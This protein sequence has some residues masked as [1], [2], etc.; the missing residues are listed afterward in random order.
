MGLRFLAV[1]L[2]LVLPARTSAEWQVKPFA[3]VTLGGG[4]TFVADLD[5]A[6]GSPKL[7]VGVNVLLLGDVFGVEA[8][9]G[10]TPGFFQAGDQQSLVL[11]SSVTTVTGNLVIA[12]PR[13]LTEY[14]IRPYVVGGAGLLRVVITDKA[15]IF[16]VNSRL[17]AVD[18]GGGATGFL[19]SRIG[20]N[21]DV[22][23]FRSVG[24][25][26]LTFGVPEQLSFWRAI[27][28]LAIRY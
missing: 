9:V 3:G 19:T 20:V 26:E 5:H 17:L 25:T 4:T 10:H 1:A 8:D 11:Q 2:L 16:P 14:T 12:A 13:D 6:A 24:Q 28:A 7:A 23:Y 18:I 15:G 21:W 22:R 27:M